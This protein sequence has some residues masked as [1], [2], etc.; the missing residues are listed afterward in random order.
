M[1]GRDCFLFVGNPGTGKSTLI[2]GVLG[3]PL[4]KAQ[5]SFNGSGVTFKLDEKHIPG[6]GRF[7][8]TPGLADEEKKRQAAA[9][10]T[11]ALKK[12]GFYR[13]FFVLTDEGGR[14]R[15]ADK[16][17]M[18]LILDA[19]PI[20]DY[21]VIIN[22]TNPKWLQ[23]MKGDPQK[24]K[25]WETTLMSGL[26][27]VSASIH[28][29]LRFDDLDGEENVKYKAP[30]DVIDF[31]KRCP[32][33]LIRPQDV[34]DVRADQM[35]ALQKEQEDLIRR[36]EQDKGEMR[37]Q[38]ELQR[39]EVAAA[40][41]RVK[42]AQ[43]RARREAMEAQKRARSEAMEAERRASEQ[44]AEAKRCAE[45]AQRQAEQAQRDAKES[46]RRADL[47][48]KKAEAQRREEQKEAMRREKQAQKQVEQALKE[49]KEREKQAQRQAEQAL[50]EAKEQEKQAR[51]R[52]EQAQR[53]AKEQEEKAQLAMQEILD[54]MVLRF[55]EQRT[56]AQQWLANENT[57]RNELAEQAAVHNHDDAVRIASHV[58]GK[59]DVLA[60][61]AD[62][63]RH[64]EVWK[65]KF[66]AWG[67]HEH[68][69]A[70][71]VHGAGQKYYDEAI[72]R[73]KSLK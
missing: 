29:M 39:A 15:P 16:A 56:W 47:K 23:K 41:A 11:E 13:I 34:K 52:A 64:V 30:T 70:S 32:G 36:M 38:L 45:Q 48:A 35:E 37:R 51:R 18:K 27:K 28:F 61:L 72:G 54:E 5:P 66:A 14:V 50:K 40:E 65:E 21:G 44:V 9:S 4:F 12:D 17:T 62:K 33:M 42:E 58:K 63:S 55:A 71:S 25:E 6:L 67:G 68:G 1:Q 49:A 57:R 31:I 69:Y 22:K 3:E 19:A 20:T 26:P 73:I 10:I 53:E 43:E 46:Q 2:N 24:M 59:N 7:M 8:D 60:Q